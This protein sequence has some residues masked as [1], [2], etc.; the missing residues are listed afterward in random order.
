MLVER[1]LVLSVNTSVEGGSDNSADRGDVPTAIS[2]LT[3]KTGHCVRRR[4]CLLHSASLKR[5][6]LLLSFLISYVKVSNVR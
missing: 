5:T 2:T 3:S 6:A 4:I 1:M